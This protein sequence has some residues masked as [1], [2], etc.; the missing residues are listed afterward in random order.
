MAISENDNSL[1]LIQKHNVEF[2]NL[3]Q[4]TEY[5]RWL[6]ASEMLPS[7][8]LDAYVF[9]EVHL[10]KALDQS[11]E[12]HFEKKP[13]LRAKLSKQWKTLVGWSKRH[14]LPELAKKIN[15]YIK[16]AILPQSQR[17]E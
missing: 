15:G 17:S 14:L 16:N 1:S 7:D 5:G 9:L 10:S 8:P 2:V 13:S 3:L 6:F 12:R 11:Y 4:E